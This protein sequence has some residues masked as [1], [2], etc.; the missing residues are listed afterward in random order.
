MQ[1][2]ISQN[3]AVPMDPDPQHSVSRAILAKRSCTVT[4]KQGDFWGFFLLC[5]IFNT[6]SS[7]APQIPLC[8]R[9]LGSRPGLLRLRYWQSADLATSVADPGYL[10]RIRL[11]SIPDPNFF[12]PGS[13]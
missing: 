4:I 5:T 1:I 13:A 12:H 3:N 2:R 11:F 6:G 9:M 7:A 10:S 8:R